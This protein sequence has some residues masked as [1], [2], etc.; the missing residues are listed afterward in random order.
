[1]KIVKRVLTILIT[2][3]LLLLLTFNI[4]S[5]I[6]INVLNKDLVTIGGYSFLEVVSGS[7]EPT[8]EIGDIVIIDTK[9]KDILEGDIITFKDTS[10]SLV[11]HRVVSYTDDKMI[12]KG[13]FNNS[14]DEEISRDNIVGKYKFKIH[15]LGLVI[16]SLQSPMTF[17]MIFIIG[18]LICFLVSTDK[19]GEPILDEDEKE[20]QEFLKHKEE[21]KKELEQE[22]TT[23]EETPKK[24]NNKKNNMAKK[25]TTNKTTSRKRK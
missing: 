22:I 18:I 19:N 23:K 17:V 16:K 21:L 3:I 11:T 20:F 6:S 1:M 24:N 12:T 15:H 4:Y 10:G 2:I 7:M 14:N 13:D 25:K 9:D 8:I 5:F